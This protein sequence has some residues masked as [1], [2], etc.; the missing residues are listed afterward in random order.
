MRDE[1]PVL[2]KYQTASIIVTDTLSGD[3]KLDGL[4]FTDAYNDSTSFEYKQMKEE[5]CTKVHMFLMSLYV[6]VCV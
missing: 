1:F 4:E 3:G 2:T 6:A 5:F